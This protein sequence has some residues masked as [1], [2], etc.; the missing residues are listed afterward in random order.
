[1]KQKTDLEKGTKFVHIKVSDFNLGYKEG[2][3]QGQSDAMLCLE[4]TLCNNCNCMTNT[5]GVK[6]LCSKCGIIKTNEV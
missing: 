3:L 1:M 6:K 5:I 2:Y 4:M